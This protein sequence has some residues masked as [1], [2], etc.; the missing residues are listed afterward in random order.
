VAQ[1]AGGRFQPDSKAVFDAG[2]RSIASTLQL[3][4]GLLG[5]AIALNLAELVMRKWKGVME[6]AKPGAPGSTA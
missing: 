3:W 5:L 1:F 4:P 6:G 2:R